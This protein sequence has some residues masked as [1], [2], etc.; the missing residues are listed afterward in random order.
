MVNTLKFTKLTKKKFPAVVT[1][2]RVKTSPTASHGVN[3]TLILQ[4]IKTLM[5]EIQTKLQKLDY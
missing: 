3:P 2:N 4:E 1:A 5:T